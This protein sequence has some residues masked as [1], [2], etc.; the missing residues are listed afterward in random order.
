MNH[1]VLLSELA[2]KKIMHWVN[3]SNDEISGFGMVKY[4]VAKK[5]FYVTDAFLVEQ[6]VTSGST[7]ID[8]KGYAKLLFQTAKLDGE[9]LFWW[10]SHVKMN[11]FW[12]TTDMDTIKKLGSRGWIIAS[13]FNQKDEIRSC[14]AFM[15]SSQLGGNVPELVVQDELDTFIEQ[16]AM[17][18]KLKKHLDEEF[19]SKVKRPVYTQTGGYGSFL[20][21]HGR[22]ARRES[23]AN[24]SASAEEDSDMMTVDATAV[25]N[26]MSQQGELDGEMLDEAIGFGLRGYGAEIE[27]EALELKY[28]TFRHMLK[29]NNPVALGN[30]E[31]RLIALESDGTLDKILKRVMDEFESN[32][33]QLPTEDL[34][35]D[36][37]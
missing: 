3:K 29:K 20:E 1:N 9:C 19:T 18:D 25:R 17:S 5:R 16:P 21:R 11:V 13:V 27:A 23:L 36:K 22:G 2:H 28:S 35:N 4:D 31:D 12:S 30:L 33:A 8:D 15:A 14:T 37:H 6:T 10:H 32:G 24:E 34:R 26:I 7:D